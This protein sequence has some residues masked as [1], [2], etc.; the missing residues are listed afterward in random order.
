MTLLNP[1]T[2]LLGLGLIGALLLGGESLK[3]HYIEEGA[4]TQLAFDQKAQDKIKADARTKLDEE[5][6]KTRSREA[7]LRDLKDKL[8]NENVIGEKALALVADRAASQRLRDPYQVSRCGTSSGSPTSS[9]PTPASSSPTNGTEAGGL[10]S[11]E[12][13]RF[14][15]SKFREADELNLAYRACRPALL[16]Q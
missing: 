7:E 15:K 13:D 2:W 10:L 6:A 5:T 3:T 11:P 1:W 8:E 4:K 16:G 14:L 12:L 9:A